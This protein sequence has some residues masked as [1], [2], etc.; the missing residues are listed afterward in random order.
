MIKGSSLRPT[1]NWR[2]Q[3]FFV[4]VLNLVLFCN[5]DGILL[6]QYVLECTSSLWEIILWRT[7]LS[8]L[9]LNMFLVKI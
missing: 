6:V 5:F 7:V 8:L 4:I 1:V 3:F 2:I 9:A